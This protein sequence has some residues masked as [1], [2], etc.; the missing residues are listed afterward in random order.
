MCG[1]G[2]LRVDHIPGVTEMAE[3]VLSMLAI[4]VKMSPRPALP[5]FMV[6]GSF[7]WIRAQAGVPG[8]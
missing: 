7:R 8:V 5:E 6:G 4:A 1:P 2:L 3:P